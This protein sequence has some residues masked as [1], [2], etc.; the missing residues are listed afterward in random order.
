V[1]ISDGTSYRIQRNQSIL[2]DAPLNCDGAG[3]TQTSSAS[4]PLASFAYRLMEYIA[5]QPLQAQSRGGVAG[6]GSE[7][8]DHIGVDVAVAVSFVSEPLDGFVNTPIPGQ[9]GFVQVL[10]A[11]EG[12]TPLPGVPVTLSVANN[13]GSTVMIS[14][15]IESTDANG[16]ATFPNLTLNKAGGYQLWA[17]ATFDGLAGNQ[18]TSILFTI[19]NQ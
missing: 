7:Y 13:S 3:P 6:M 1:C 5:P 11:T 9:N 17:N 19:K 4:N 2:I 15:E 8:S 16:I 12:G 14:G 10:V 18:A